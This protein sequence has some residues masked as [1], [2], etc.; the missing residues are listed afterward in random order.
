MTTLLVLWTLW[1]LVHSLL[2]SRP[3]NRW[4]ARIDGW[5]AAG[6]RLG[7]IV[8]SCLSLIPL[9]VYQFRLP[10]HIVFDWH[11]WGRLIQLGL[12]TYSLIMFRGGYLVYDT[13]YFFGWR[14]WR[15]FR[16]G[17]AAHEQFPFRCQ[18]VL[19]YVRHPWYSGGLTLL[20]GLG[21]YTNLTLAVRVLLSFYIVV[22]TMLEE[23]KLIDEL[24]DEY[25]RYQRQVPML[26]PWKGRGGDGD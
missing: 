6:W 5:L 11:G 15:R 14:Q 25:R 1:C 9:L 23:R 2:V 16:Q 8:F 4:L 26:I 12:L 10:Q 20:W 19:R 18:G 13:A 21:P 7:Y 17:Q 24:G 22:G 3:V